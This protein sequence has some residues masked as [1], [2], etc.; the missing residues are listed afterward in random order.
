MVSFFPRCVMPTEATDGGP[1]RLPLRSTCCRYH[2]VSVF[3]ISALLRCSSHHPCSHGH[4][5]V[6]GDEPATGVLQSYSISHGAQDQCHSGI[7]WQVITGGQGLCVARHVR[8]QAAVC[9]VP[10]GILDADHARRGEQN[11]C[12]A[13]HAQIVCTPRGGRPATTLFAWCTQLGAGARC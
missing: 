4:N 10:P 11:A 8:S 2:N 12:N 5:T 3:F 6:V 1:G 13:V 9:P 7:C